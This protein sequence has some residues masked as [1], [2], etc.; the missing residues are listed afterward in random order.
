MNPAWL[1]LIEL[2]VAVAAVVLGWLVLDRM[3]T[4]FNDLD[5]IFSREGLSYAIL[6]A[7]FLI[8]QVWGM[9]SV[10]R[11]NPTPDGIDILWV[12]VAGVTVTATLLL[13]YVVLSALIGR[14]IPNKVVPTRHSMGGNFNSK[15]ELTDPRGHNTGLSLLKACF[16][17]SVGLIYNGAFAGDAVGVRLGTALGATATFVA[18]GLAVLLV[19]YMVHNRI[20]RFIGGYRISALVRKGELPACIEA[21]GVALGLGIILQ[22]A[23][24]GDF[25]SWYSAFIGF[26]VTLVVALVLTYALKLGFSALVLRGRDRLEVLHNSDK[27]VA[28]GFTALMLPLAA[29]L[30]SQTATSVAAALLL[31]TS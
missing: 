17:V 7:G 2:L 23:I 21:A 19:W 14:D 26:F 27:P 31:L 18:V 22:A 29:L 20:T 13:V 15:S 5:E 30:S 9:Y 3:T 1:S 16:F 8:G 28:V 4:T 10:L 11:Y 24:A 6:R 12:A 25:T